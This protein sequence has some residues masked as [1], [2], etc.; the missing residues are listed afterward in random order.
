MML[1]N[2]LQRDL[3]VR[4]RVRARVLSGGQG[5]SDGGEVETL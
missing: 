3:Q 5:T 2:R 4:A 1:V